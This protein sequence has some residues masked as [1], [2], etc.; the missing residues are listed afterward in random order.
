[1]LEKKFVH[2]KCNLERQIV[3]NWGAWSKLKHLDVTYKEMVF[4]VLIFYVPKKL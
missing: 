3:L 4:N 2:S 1:M